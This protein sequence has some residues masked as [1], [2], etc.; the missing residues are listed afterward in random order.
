MSHR[1]RRDGR[2]ARRLPEWLIGLLLAI[3]LVVAGA[4]ILTALGA[5]DDPTFDPEGA[6][7]VLDA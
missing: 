2:P 4:L 6:V 1:D 7:H 5:G 3:V